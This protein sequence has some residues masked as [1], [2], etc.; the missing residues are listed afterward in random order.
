MLFLTPN[1]QHQSTEGNYSGK[2]SK[3]KKQLGLA[4]EIQCNSATAVHLFIVAD[5]H[6]Y[7]LFSG[8]T[9]RTLCTINSVLVKW[10]T[11]SVQSAY[12]KSQLCKDSWGTTVKKNDACWY[13][14][15]YSTLSPGTVVL[16]WVTTFRLAIHPCQL[17]LLLSVRWE[18]S[19]NQSVLMLCSWGVSPVR[20][21]L[22]VDIS[23]IG[24]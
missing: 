15:S 1:Q 2:R 19:T 11:N 13:P 9:F 24:R 22:L 17:S 8:E 10:T 14:W 20:L 7:K 18:I 23:A 16:E 21:I 5:E 12:S 3:N 6:E 4:H